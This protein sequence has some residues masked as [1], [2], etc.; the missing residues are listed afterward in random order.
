[1]AKIT[2]IPINDLKTFANELFLAELFV[3]EFFS[4]G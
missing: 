3:A 2:H 4:F 1:M